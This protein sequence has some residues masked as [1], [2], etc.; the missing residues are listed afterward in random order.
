MKKIAA[1]LETA[2]RKLTTKSAVRNVLFLIMGLFAMMFTYDM[3]ARY[4]S[5]SYSG[6][7]E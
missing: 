3:W 7:P 1:W 2:F 4:A 6:L 5:S